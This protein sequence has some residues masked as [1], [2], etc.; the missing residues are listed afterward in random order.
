MC[1]VPRAQALPVFVPNIHI[2][3][4]ASRQVISKVVSG[5]GVL[6]IVLHVLGRY[7]V[8]VYVD[9]KGYLLGAQKSFFFRNSFPKP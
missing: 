8:I 9:D 6:E 4:S 2:P 1:R 5:F 7:M 3:E